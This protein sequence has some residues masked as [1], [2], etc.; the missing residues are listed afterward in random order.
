VLYTFTVRAGGNWYTSSAQIA[1]G[2][3]QISRKQAQASPTFLT[4]IIAITRRFTRAQLNPMIF[5]ELGKPSYKIY[6]TSRTEL[7]LPTPFANL[8]C[9]IFV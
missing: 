3:L 7:A 1:T 6:T 9:K 4:D 8:I 5:R 2:D